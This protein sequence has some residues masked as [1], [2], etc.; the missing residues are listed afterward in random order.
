MSEDQELAALRQTID[1]I[2]R[3]LVA[4]INRRARAAQQVA[5]VKRAHNAAVTTF[6]RPEREAD[7]LRRIQRENPGPLD[8][9]EVARLFREIMSACLALEERQTVA[10]LGPEGT[11]TQT[12][13]LK[14]FG[15]SVLTRPLNAINEVFREVEARNCEYGVVPIENSTEGVVNHTLDSFLQ[16]SLKICGEVELRIHQHLL[17]R[18]V[19]LDEIE[20]LYSHPQ[21][22]AQCREWLDLHLPRAERIHAS[23]NADAA[24]RASREPNAAAIAG[25]SAAEIYGLKVLHNNIEDNPENITRFLV[26][27]QQAVQ[28]S[29]LDKT[30]LLVS[31]ANRPGSL[32]RLLKPFA[33]NGVSLSRI[34]SRP[35]HCVN[36]EYVFF[37]DLLGHVDDPHIRQAL[38]QLGADAEMVRVLGSYPKAVL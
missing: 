14:H 11:F 20:R 36:W 28:P 33:D 9:E 8:N 25:E 16:S 18:E 26:I 34:E 3:D 29:G 10:Y 12:A 1:Q 32:Y 15:H 35:S 31:A 37:L 21:S 13:A 30:S 7:V 27:G 2:D 19:G 5:A 17:G 23:S 4:L 38:A 6:Y 22:L 24:R